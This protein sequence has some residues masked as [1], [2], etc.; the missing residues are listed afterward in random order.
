MFKCS[1]CDPLLKVVIEKGKIA[2]EAVLPTFRDFPWA[3]M[4]AKMRTAK[5]GEIYFSPSLAFTNL[6]DGRSLEISIVEDKK[7]TVFYLF[8]GESADE[9][10][11]MEL[12]DQ[13]A[14][15]QVR[16]LWL[17]SPLV[18][19]RRR[20]CDAIQSFH[21]TTHISGSDA[22]CRCSRHVRRLSRASCGCG[23]GP[24]SS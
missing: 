14:E 2:R 12:L 6:E 10:S 17:S 22:G 9:S 3:S 23:P 21:E 1:I 7:E 5:E 20:S 15:S 16:R 24:L 19:T 13:S 18:A 4:L 8:Y 11:R